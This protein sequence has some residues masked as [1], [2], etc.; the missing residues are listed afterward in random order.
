ML[1]KLNKLQLLKKG[2]NTNILY[3][4]AQ[5]GTYIGTDDFMKEALLYSIEETRKAY[6]SNKPVIWCSTFIPSEL[7]YSLG[8][9]PFMPEVA[10]G[11]A[12][13]IGMADRALIESEGDW[14]NTDLC[15]IHRCGTGLMKQGLLPEPDYIIASSHLCDGAKKYLQYISYQYDVPF[16]LLETPYYR[17][18]APWLA[19]Q[20]KEIIKD[21]GVGT[22]FESVFNYSNKAYQYHKKINQLR[23][24]DS[25][26]IPGDRVLNLIPLEFMSFGSKQGVKYFRKLAET[27]CERLENEELIVDEQK[28]RLLWLHLK[29]YYS[30][31]IFSTLRNKGAVIAFEEYSQLYWDQ[32][33]IERPYLS[34]AQKMID[35]F[36]WGP[37]QD[38]PDNIISLV[39]E[40]KI[41]GVIGFSQWGCRQSNGR[42]DIVNKVLKEKGIPFLNID[43]DLVDSR[44]YR[45]EQLITR[46]E[47]FIELIEIKKESQL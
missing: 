8:G 20:L 5:A 16:Y 36:G 25:V 43:G 19:E 45:E 42:M 15:S 7:V 35:H 33:E 21:I 6:N 13:T 11:F 27:L 2:L 41:D 38:Q 34:L 40:Y 10:A 37:L 32:L 28:H 12:A 29:P 3:R 17:E 26:T 24:K 39:D 23:K 47:A 9:V 31:Q 14:F 44:N 4:L 22:Q 1:N 30:Q 46:L 18:E